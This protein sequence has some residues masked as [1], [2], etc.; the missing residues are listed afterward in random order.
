[1]SDLA[2]CAGFK[3]GKYGF[4]E[5]VLP[6]CG[7]GDSVKPGVER[8]ETPGL[9]F[10]NNKSPRSGRQPNNYK[11]CFRNRNR[12]RPLRG[13]CKVFGVDGPLRVSVPLTPRC[14]L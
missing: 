13:L 10:E 4:V 3:V 8:S 7:A 2:R 1:S 12:Y 5:L 11:R 14:L 6:T 9:R